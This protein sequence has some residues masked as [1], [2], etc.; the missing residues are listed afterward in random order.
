MKKCC[1][2]IVLSF[3]T[4]RVYGIHDL[5]INGSSTPTITTASTL[6]ITAS[7]DGSNSAN[8]TIYVDLN[9]NGLD[10]S[11][12]WIMKSKMIDG[13]FDDEDET[14]NGVYHEIGDPFMFQGKIIFYAEDNGVSDT[15][16]MT[17]NPATSSH[18]VSGKVT[19]PA[20]K[21]HIFVSTIRI[22]N[23]ENGEFEYGCGDFTDANGNYSISMPDECANQY[24][25]VVAL[26]IAEV[27]PFYSSNDVTNDS[28]YVLGTVTKNIE[29]CFA[30]IVTRLTGELRDDLG[31]LI[32]APAQ[33]MGIGSIDGFKRAK[34]GKTDGTGTYSIFIKTASI[35][36]C[37]YMTQA[38]IAGQLYPDFMNPLH[39]QVMQ[40]PPAD[41]LITINF[42]AYRTTN[43]ISGYVYKDG[44]P[45]DKCHLDCSAVGYG[46]TYAKTF[47]DGSYLMPV[48]DSASSYTI[49]I[50][51]ESIPEGYTISSLS[52]TASPGATDINS[53]FVGVEEEA[54]DIV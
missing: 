7:F 36:I 15:V 38:S 29:M 26:D 34:P 48:S 18:S 42:K 11:D 53:N 43:F 44:A 52:Q 16:I 6:D 4:F 31:S 49:T 50:A 25:K 2:I 10:P 12:P 22:I 46:G 47:S 8:V 17:V 13:G 37:F 27:V 21:P 5:L 23:I 9:N 32:T 41:S 39:K 30:S 33:V 28:I 20:N 35:G 3:F 1:F 24:W 14:I 19:V 51:K 54:K 40:F 45:Y